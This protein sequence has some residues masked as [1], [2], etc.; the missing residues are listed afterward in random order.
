M[1]ETFT[2][3]VCGET[4]TKARTDEEALAE[5][6]ELFG[7]VDDDEMEVIC[8]SCFLVLSS[9]V[10]PRQWASGNFF[11]LNAAHQ[12]VPCSL[13]EWSARFDDPTPNIVGQDKLAADVEVSTVFLGL[14][15][16][17]GPRARSHPLIF[18]TLVFGGELDGATD[19]YSTWAQ[20]E[21]GH[22]AMIARVEATL[23]ATA[24]DLDG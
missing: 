9:L 2:C 19:R 12:A 17:F 1:E 21:A 8:N 7:P 24:G 5:T 10:D 6:V 4:F 14:N 15:H 16:N 20:A 22:R 18:E 3:A 23:P 13:V 11:K